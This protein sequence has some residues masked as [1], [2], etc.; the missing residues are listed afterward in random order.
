MKVVK[1][2]VALLMVVFI[3]ACEKEAKTVSYYESHLTEAKEI[4][5]KCSDNIEEL[6]A[7]CINAAKAIG[8]VT[9]K[10]VFSDG[11]DIN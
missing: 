5:S 2:S 11:I 8:N 7:D 9:T 3:S 10:S 1:A 6:S 4:A